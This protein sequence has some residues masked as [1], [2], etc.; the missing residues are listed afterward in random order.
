MRVPLGLSGMK[1][2][3]RN[4]KSRFFAARSLPSNEVKGSAQNDRLLVYLSANRC[5][6]GNL[7]VAKKY[8]LMH[9]TFTFMV[10]FN[11]YKKVKY[12]V[13]KVILQKLRDLE[14]EIKDDL[15]A[16]RELLG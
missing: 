2:L 8:A 15:L 14:E 6:I 16:P 4:E 12:K 13:S 9:P 3:D 5:K 11:R 10:I 1:H 7:V